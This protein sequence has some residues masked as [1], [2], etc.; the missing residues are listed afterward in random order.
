MTPEN[1]AKYDAKW[2]RIHDAIALREPDQIPM[3]PSP[4]IFPIFHAGHTMTEA[5][6][7]ETLEVARTSMLKYL[8]DYDPDNGTAITNYCG[9]GRLMELQ[10]PTTMKWSG[11]P[12][13]PIGDNSLQQFVEFPILLDDEFDEFFGDRMKWTLTRELPREFDSLKP[14][15]DFRLGRGIMGLA[16]AVSK[17]EMREMIQKLW[18]IRL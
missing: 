7:D 15:T 3:T 1:K 9:E 18:E 5:I 16:A 11:M 14:L 8:H 4:S 2:N 17:P 12:G 10:Q 13:N 6:Y